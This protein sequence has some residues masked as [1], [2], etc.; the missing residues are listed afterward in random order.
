MNKFYVSAGWRK[1]RGYKLS[2]HP[3]CERC[4]PFLVAATEVHHIKEV[5]THPGL[6]LEYHNLESL[7]KS[8]HSSHTAKTHR[9]KK[10]RI[11][12]HKWK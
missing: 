10:G 12:N 2:T 5:K 11:I 9:M 8:C 3:F 1:L 6:S 7:C 4:L